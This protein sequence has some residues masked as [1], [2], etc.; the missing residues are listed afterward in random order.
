MPKY[1]KGDRVP[2]LYY[3]GHTTAEI[4]GMLPD[5][6]RIRFASYTGYLSAKDAHRLTFRVFEAMVT[7]RAYIPEY[8]ED[9]WKGLIHAKI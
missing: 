6:Y 4:V 3:N 2:V 7:D 9:A 1:K 5:A 8:A